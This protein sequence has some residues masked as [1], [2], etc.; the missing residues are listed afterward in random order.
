MQFV[1]FYTDP[2][3]N[4]FRRLIPPIGMLDISPVIAFFCLG[5]IEQLIKIVVSALLS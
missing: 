2:Y 3:L 4:I 5:L 1:A